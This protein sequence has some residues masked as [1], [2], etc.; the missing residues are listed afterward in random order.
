MVYAEDGCDPEK[1][2]VFSASSTAS[3][4]GYAMLGRKETAFDGQ[5]TSGMGEAIGTRNWGLF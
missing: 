3:N 1:A 4:S 2:K 5:F